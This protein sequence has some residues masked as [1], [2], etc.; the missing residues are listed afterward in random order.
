MGRSS[1]EVVTTCGPLVD[2]LASGALGDERLNERRNRVIAVLERQPDTGFPDA[3]ADD[4]EVEAFYRFLRNRRVSLP[5]IL[6]PHVEATHGRCA[7]IAECSCCT[8][9]PIWSSRA[10]PRGRD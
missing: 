7:A 3:C 9:P 6:A 8:T 2:E 10:R 4:A 1:H 5:A